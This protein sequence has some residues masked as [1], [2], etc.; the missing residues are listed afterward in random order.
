MI[1]PSIDIQD[2]KAVQLVGGRDR[3]LEAGDPREVARRFSVA[4]ELAVIDL[5]AATGLGSNRDIVLEIVRSHPCRVGGGIRSAEAALDWLDAGAEKVILGT[6]AEPELL[7]RLPPERVIA[8]LDA[9]DGEVVVEGWTTATGRRVEDRIDELRSHVGGFLLTFVEREGRLN[10]T[11]L[12]AA[13]RLVERAAPASVT[14]AGGVTTAEEIRLLDRIG[15]GAQVGMALYTGKLSLAEAFAAPLVSD[16]SDGLWPTVV[17]DEAGTALGLAYSSAE[18]LARAVELRQ[19][20]YHSRRRGVWVKGE[21]SGN[22]QRLLRADADCDRDALRFTV[23]QEG[24]GFCHK[25]TRSCWG[26]DAGLKRLARRA[27]GRL[28]EA[29]AGSYTRRL[30]DDPE[31]LRAKLIEEA[32]ELAAARGP[33]EVAWEAADLLY[34]ATVALARA[35]VPLAAAERVLDGRALAVRRRSD[36]ETPPREGVR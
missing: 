25:A 23:R 13:R 19:G 1:V 22:H 10:G 14:I 26:E 35:G 28:R 29:P 32:E 36:A 24:V 21:S 30:A 3:A 9:V 11:D 2:G 12:E 5:D 33:V 31:L 20:V 17:C 16:R 18:S 15:A 27:A 7:D 8:A 34:F 6:A 4:G